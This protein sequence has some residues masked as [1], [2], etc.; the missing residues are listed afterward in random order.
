MPFQS[1]ARLL[2]QIGQDTAITEQQRKM[3]KSQQ[4]K[5]SQLKK[6]WLKF[7]R[8]YHNIYKQ[9]INGETLL[10]KWGVKSLQLKNVLLT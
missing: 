1:A 5:T 3:V 2:S 4:M 9:S 6:V 7:A 8:V 10:F